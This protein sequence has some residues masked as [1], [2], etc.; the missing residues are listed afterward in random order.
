MSNGKLAFQVGRQA[1]LVWSAENM[2]AVVRFSI[3]SRLSIVPLEI[4]GCSGRVF[5]FVRAKRKTGRSRL[6]YM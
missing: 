5:Q 4:E 6:I 1:C 3:P 2:L